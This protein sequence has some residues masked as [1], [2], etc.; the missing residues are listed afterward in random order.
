MNNW[1]EIS[2]NVFEHQNQEDYIYKDKIFMAP[3]W[4]AEWTVVTVFTHS[5]NILL[6]ILEVLIHLNM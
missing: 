4:A 3:E 6:L 5:F 2:V 1:D